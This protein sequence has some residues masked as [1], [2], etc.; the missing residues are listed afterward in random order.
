MP[1]HPSTGTL[2]SD[3]W[4]DLGHLELVAD[5]RVWQS[6]VNPSATTGFSAHQTLLKSGNSRD[7][8]TLIEVQEL[9]VSLVSS[10]T[11]LEE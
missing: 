2:R 3:Q 5:T 7:K 8:F 4:A 9:L 11:L 6:P 10:L 1:P